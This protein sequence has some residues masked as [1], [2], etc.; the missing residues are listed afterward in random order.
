MLRAIAE[1]PIGPQDL[2]V[3]VS[4]GAVAHPVVAGTPVDTAFR[5]ADAA[6]YLAKQRGRNCA[7]CVATLEPGSLVHACEDLAPAERAGQVELLSVTGPVV[8]DA[9]PA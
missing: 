8:L 1:T 7:L 4:A 3:T 2:Q 5:L 6:M 9:T